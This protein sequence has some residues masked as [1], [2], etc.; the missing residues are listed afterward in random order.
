MKFKNFF[1]FFNLQKC[2][3]HNCEK[4]LCTGKR[5]G[6]NCDPIGPVECEKGAYCSYRTK[7][8]AKQKL[9]G[10]NCDDVEPKNLSEREEGENFMVICP[11]GT[12]CRRNP[13]QTESTCQEIYNSKL[14]EECSA[15]DECE[16]P[17][18]C[19]NQKCSESL[20]R[21]F[22]CG[23]TNCTSSNS[24]RC[25]CDSE[26]NPGT[27]KAIVAGGCDWRTYQ[28]VRQKEKLKIISNGEDVGKIII[29][30]MIKIGFSQF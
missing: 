22:P 10:E 26:G 5:V 3:S 1:L 14:G 23:N 25:I 16:V 27:C 24:E 15:S 12:K 8:C 29:V 20:P 2:H 19:T 4:S 28:K 18:V 6:E 17:L 7:T 11:G 21:V 13:S 9:K 30:I